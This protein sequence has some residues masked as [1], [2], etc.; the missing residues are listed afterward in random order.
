MI[1]VKILTVYIHHSWILDLHKEF[2]R[3]KIME[4]IY[5]TKP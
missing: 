1:Y 3:M 2:V 4:G 5:E